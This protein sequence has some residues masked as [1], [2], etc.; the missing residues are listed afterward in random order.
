MKWKLLDIIVENYALQYVDISQN[1]LII[2]LLLKVIQQ[3]KDFEIIVEFLEKQ[4]WNLF[5][6]SDFNQQA[7][8][9][10]KELKLIVTSATLDAVKFSQYFFEAVSLHTQNE[11]WIGKRLK[12]SYN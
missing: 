10:R 12:M 5:F 3:L 9:K 2:L 11:I 6:I 7:V 4:H 1:V 8:L